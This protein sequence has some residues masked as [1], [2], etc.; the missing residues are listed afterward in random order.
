MSE[1]F[2][3]PVVG[4]GSG[5]D[6]ENKFYKVE[7]QLAFRNNAMPFGSATS[8]YHSHRDALHPDPL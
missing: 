4:D 1:N 8:R 5:L 7:L 2:P 6:T 3:L